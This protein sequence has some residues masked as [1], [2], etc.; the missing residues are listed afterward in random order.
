MLV[1]SQAALL[2][3][4]DVKTKGVVA[5]SLCITTLTQK[6]RLHTCTT[7][8]SQQVLLPNRLLELAVY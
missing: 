4:C 5:Y 3:R 6:A 2:G 8:Q 7:V 1:S